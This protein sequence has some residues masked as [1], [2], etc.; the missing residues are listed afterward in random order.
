[1]QKISKQYAAKLKAQV[2]AGATGKDEDELI[3]FFIDYFMD[4]GE[5]PYGIQKA[6]TGDPGNWTADK[7]E[8]YGNDEL[9]DI[10]DELT[11]SSAIKSIFDSKMLNE[12]EMSAPRKQILNK[13][14]SKMIDDIE[15]Y[16]DA[17]KEGSRLATMILESGG[18]D[19]LLK[20]IHSNL[21]KMYNDLNDLLM[22]CF[23]EE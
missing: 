1:M 21:S 17:T 23:I 4:N 5:M 20:Y 14:L 8:E 13:N 15:K 16:A 18:D 12:T 7:M 11:E 10:I 3:D 22:S 2:R 6:R 9:C 19:K